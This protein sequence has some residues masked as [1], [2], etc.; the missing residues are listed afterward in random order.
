MGNVAFCTG[1]I[2]RLACR[3]VSASAEL[4]VKLVDVSYCMGI[5]ACSLGL[6]GLGFRVRDKVCMQIS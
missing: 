4:L 5:R 3:A 1:G 6:V 2:Q